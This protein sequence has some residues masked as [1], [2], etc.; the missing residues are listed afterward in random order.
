MNC[1]T[2]GEPIEPGNGWVSWVFNVDKKSSRGLLLTHHLKDRKEAA[3]Y[4]QRWRELEQ[5][6]D[7]PSGETVLDHSLEV[8]MANDGE[9]LFQLLNPDTRDG[10][11]MDPADWLRVAKPLLQEG[12]AKPFVAHDSRPLGGA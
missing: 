2:C 10:Y 9:R 8:F 11:G 12:I 4:C 1:D 6:G 7:L 5:M 3:T